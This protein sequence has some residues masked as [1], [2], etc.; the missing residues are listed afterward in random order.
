MSKR[1]KEDTTAYLAKIKTY[2]RR[3]QIRSGAIDGLLE[4]DSKA[5]RPEV[6]ALIEAALAIRLGALARP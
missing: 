6:K 5:I 4:R 1:M 2:A 3:A